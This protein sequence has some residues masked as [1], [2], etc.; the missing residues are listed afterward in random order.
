MFGVFHAT[1]RDLYQEVNQREGIDAARN[2]E[3][4]TRLRHQDLMEAFR[5][6]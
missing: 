2:E 4:R 1:P 5:C 6:R 3:T